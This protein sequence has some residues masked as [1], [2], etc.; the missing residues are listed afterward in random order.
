MS[1][2]TS[3]IQKSEI[4]KK[5]AQSANESIKNTETIINNFLEAIGETLKKNDKVSCVGFGTFKAKNTPKRKGRNPQTGK[6]ITISARR[7]VRFT[8]GALLK[9]KVNN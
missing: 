8:P 9:K 1:T 7:E 2:K 4:I 5:V 6:E 3:A